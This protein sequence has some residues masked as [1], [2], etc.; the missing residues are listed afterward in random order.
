MLTKDALLATC[1]L[2]TTIFKSSLGEVKLRQLNIQETKVITAMHDDPTKN[3]FDIVFYT[4][5]KALVEPPFFTE[6][7]LTTLGPRGQEFMFE[8]YQQVPL[9]GLTDAEIAEH[10]KKVAEFVKIEE[11]K[12]EEEKKKK[13]KR[14]E[15][16]S[17]N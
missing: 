8:L 6:E 2:Q 15:S 10:K 16:S 9:I 12:S 14:S 13:T 1:M 3:L 4:L 5:S 7:E 17:L 11:E